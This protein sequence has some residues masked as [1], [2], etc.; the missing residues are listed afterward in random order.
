MS[1]CFYASRSLALEQHDT[2][3][4]VIEMS[5]AKWLVAALVPGSNASR[6]RRQSSLP[7]AH[8]ET[9]QAVWRFR[10]TGRV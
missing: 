3:V 5:Q 9:R 7:P 6:S 1:Q 2:I 10:P 4:A 8:L